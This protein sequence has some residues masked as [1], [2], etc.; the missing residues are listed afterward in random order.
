MSY[1]GSSVYDEFNKEPRT[2]EVPL[3]FFMTKVFSVKPLYSFSTMVIFE[4]IASFLVVYVPLVLAVLW[5]QTSSTP[6]YNSYLISQNMTSSDFV[7]SS[8]NP[9]NPSVAIGIA[10]ASAIV[11]FITT[12]FM[13]GIAAHP[14]LLFE[15]F[16]LEVVCMYKSRAQMNNAGKVFFFYLFKAASCVGVELGGAIAGAYLVQYSIGTDA[17]NR[18]I[19]YRSDKLTSDD[20]KVIY[21]EMLFFG[22]S[23]LVYNR[24]YRTSPMGHTPYIKAENGSDSFVLAVVQFL[25]VLILYG[26]TGS[27]LNILLPFAAS[28]ASGQ[29]SNEAGIL[30]VGEL[31]GGSIAFI[32][33]SIIY[34]LPQ[35][36]STTEMNA[37]EYHPYMEKDKKQ[38][39]VGVEEMLL[40]ASN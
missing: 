22:I 10:S 34:H 30:F 33:T 15:Q 2:R 40:S 18:H 19:V 8:L 4:F 35:V 38:K 27:T 23:S 25:S 11:I 3:N 39:G 20:K 5:S 13:Q 17:F 6:A 29:N 26:I 32:V 9:K 37:S 14:W 16:F 7:D 21:L 36:L 1:K 12:R 31:V 28:I 24:F